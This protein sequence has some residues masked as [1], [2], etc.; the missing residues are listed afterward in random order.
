MIYIYNVLWSV[1]VIISIVPTVQLSGMKSVPSLRQ[2]AAKAL[3][4]P[5]ETLE[6]IKNADIQVEEF[7]CSIKQALVSALIDKFNGELSQLFIKVILGH[8]DKICAIA[9]SPDGNSIVTAADNDTVAK[10]WDVATENIVF[11]FSGHVLGVRSV[12]ISNNKSIVTG[13]EDDT[14]K[15]WSR[16]TGQ[17]LATLWHDD[18]VI[19]KSVD[20]SSDGRYVVASWVD[21]RVR[22]W[23]TQKTQ[24]TLT[25]C[26]GQH[27][28]TWVRAI[29]ISKDGVYIITGSD[30]GTVKVWQRATGQELITFQ[31]HRTPIDR[32]VMSDNNDYIVT[33]SES[34]ASRAKVWHRIT[35]QLLLV[36][37][38]QYYLILSIAI[39]GDGNLIVTGCDDGAVRVWD[40]ATGKLVS[41]LQGLISCI[42]SVSITSDGTYVASGS[43]EGI[44]T[45]YNLD[46]LRRIIPLERLLCAICQ[47]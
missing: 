26:H 36:L 39:N 7:P 44:V 18:M 24:E 42:T 21:N 14:V 28:Y 32:L 12:A 23:D 30:D 3:I 29:A 11:A 41:I 34:S 15:I 37:H 5:A 31:A 6:D 25:L 47:K 13:S 43:R 20:I 16:D 4:R 8:K 17:Q 40:R 1:F 38:D 33:F 22:V 9:L 46:Y 10:L 27:K 2:L 45:V 35:G 19:I